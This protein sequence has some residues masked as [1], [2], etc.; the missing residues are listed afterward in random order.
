MAREP[1]NAKARNLLDQIQDQNPDDALVSTLAVEKEVNT[2][3]RLQN[4]SVIAQLK[5]EFPDLEDN[6]DSKTVFL[7]LRQLRNSW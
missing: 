3:F 2:F 5:L 4:P 6:P 1:D 7:K